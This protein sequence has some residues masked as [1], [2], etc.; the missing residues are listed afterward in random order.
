MA[1]TWIM[2][3]DPHVAGAEW[4]WC[5]FDYATA[6]TMSDTLRVGDGTYVVTNLDWQRNPTCGEVRQKNVLHAK[7]FTALPPPRPIVV[8]PR[9]Q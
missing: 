1:Y 3:L 7:P 2:P 5:Q 4:S 6:R 9:P 8:D